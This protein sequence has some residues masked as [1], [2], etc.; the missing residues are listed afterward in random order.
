MS[1]FEKV[2]EAVSLK[3]FASQFLAKSTG[4]L[5]C[6]PVCGSGTHGTGNSD[7]A[8]SITGDGQFFKCFSCEA[9]G[10][11]FD[12]A[13]IVWNIPKEDKRAQLEAVANWAGMSI[14]KPASFNMPKQKRGGLVETSNHTDQRNKE[15][16]YV[17]QTRDNIEHPDAVAYLEARGFTL[18]DA[19]S[20]GIGYDSSR[21]R[22][23]LPWR[24]AEWYHVDRAIDED[25]KPKYLKPK[26]EQVGKQP[27]YN[28]KAAELPAYFI[29][30]GVLDAIAVQ[31]CGY[32]A[33]AIASNTISD[34]NLT[35]LAAGI[36]A[37]RSNGVAVIMLDNDEAGRDGA[38]KVYNAL[39]AAG[40]VCMYADL[41][42]NA[43]K[44]AAEWLK[45]DR[46]GLTA[47]LC[48]RFKAAYIAREEL[49]EQAYRDALKSFRVISPADVAGD[50][51]TLADCEEPIP[52]GIKA[53]DE[54]LD[55]GMRSGLYALGALSSMGKTTLAVQ[56]ADYIAAH[57]RGVL[58]V[59]IEQSAREIVSKSLSRMTRT[60]SGK[61]ISSTECVSRSRRD[62]WSD[63]E[64]AA[65]L[66]A[67]EAYSRDVAPRLRILEGT[68]QPSVAD[69]ETVARIIAEHDGEPPII[70]IDYL[71]LVK[72]GSEKDTD[73]QAV[74]RNV[75]SLRQL[76]RD[77]RTPIFVISSLNRGSYS[78]GVTLDAFKESGAIEYGCDVLLGLQPYGIRETINNTPETRQKRAV[79]NKIR[80]HKAGDERACELVV[81]KNRNGRTPNEGIPLTFYP[82]SAMYAAGVASMESVKKPMM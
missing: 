56:I 74:D 78:G 72:P 22:L 27:L 2:K 21:R 15:A 24:G 35:E 7:G 75:M 76:A 77:L 51:F 13:G 40:V 81:L 60:L 23:I 63:E 8:L 80:A 67:C 62:Y 12:L 14:E 79:D 29:V 50:I 66:G 30:E 43:P 46:G 16:E 69:I 82:L 18:Q 70:I 31:L 17:K 39:T 11:I 36:K 61:V 49:Q 10:D 3:D 37:K 58:F 54:I 9:Q 6:C 53:L 71:Q 55:G 34:S 32:H 65:F 25:V 45:V 41:E 5:W 59:T 73:K 19:K 33:I 4:G 28:P 38:Q 47:F 20:A 57:G 26:T 44:D 42:A 48:D 64:T 1:E 52:T 68:R